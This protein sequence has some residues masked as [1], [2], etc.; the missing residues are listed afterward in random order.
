MQKC[1][2][3]SETGIMTDNRFTQY[4]RRILFS[5]DTFKT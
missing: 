1:I 2:Q 4:L 3:K 5:G